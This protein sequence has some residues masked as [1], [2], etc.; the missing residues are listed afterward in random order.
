MPIHGHVLTRDNGQHEEF[1]MASG[2]MSTAEFQHFLKTVAHLLVK[3]TKNGSIHYICMDWRHIYDLLHACGPCYAELKNICIWN[4]NNGG[5]GSLYRSK[6]E[7]IAVFKN[8]TAPHCNNVELG[9]HGRYRTNVW[10]YVGQNSPH[11]GHMEELAMHPTVKPV[12]MVA[13]AI[14]DCS[15]RRDLVLDPF[16]GSGSTLIAAER[17]GRC[18]S[19]LELEP[20]YVDITIRRWQKLTGKTA[21]HEQTGQTFDALAASRGEV[22][23]V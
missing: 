8:G 18:A 14:Y 12:S 4:K 7:M 10:D 15:H 13:D 5:M 1:A 19:L 9:K 22:C 17:T 6:H 16:G 2:E 21:L 3:S 20:R 11:E 23:F